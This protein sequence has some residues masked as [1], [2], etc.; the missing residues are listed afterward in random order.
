VG[1]LAVLLVGLVVAIPKDAARA[2]V[3]KEGRRLK[4]GTC[5]GAKSSIVEITQTASASS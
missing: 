2:R 1:R 3:R 4:D 5:D